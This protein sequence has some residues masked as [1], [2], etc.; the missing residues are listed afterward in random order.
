MFTSNLFPLLPRLPRLA[1]HRTCAL[2]HTPPFH[3]TAPSPRTA[4]PLTT[5]HTLHSDPRRYSPA[6]GTRLGPA[7][8]SQLAQCEFAYGALGIVTPSV[9]HVV[10]CVAA[11]FHDR[12]FPVSFSLH[13]SSFPMLLRRLAHPWIICPC[14]RFI[15]THV[16]QFPLRV[17]V[18]SSICFMFRTW[19]LGYLYNMYSWLSCTVV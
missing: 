14:S 11:P 6:S 7:S 5:Q 16:F 3:D 8:L 10:T 1:R 12:F 19:Y 9:G 13:L 4:A 2:R 17:P 15:I 18:G